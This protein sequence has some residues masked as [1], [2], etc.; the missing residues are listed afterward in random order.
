MAWDA[1]SFPRIA[2][3]ASV[4]LTGGFVLRSD[5]EKMALGHVDGVTNLG[6]MNRTEFVEE[7]SKSKVLVGIGNPAISPTCVC[8]ASASAILPRMLADARFFPSLRHAARTRVRPVVS[9][10]LPRSTAWLTDSL[11]PRARN[12]ALCLGEHDP[13]PLARRFFAADWQP[14]PQASPS[15]T[16]SRSL[17]PPTRRTACAGGRSTTA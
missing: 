2:A 5:P 14:S 4:D 15:S 3:A 12:S 16:R 8:P 13:C 6:R 10:L 17:T 7:M 1:P 11:H 9:T